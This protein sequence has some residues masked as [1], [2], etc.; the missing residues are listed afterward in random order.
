MCKAL[1]DFLTDEMYLKWR[2]ESVKLILC[3]MIKSNNICISTFLRPGIGDREG[4]DSP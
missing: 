2:N 3:N 4:V 1:K